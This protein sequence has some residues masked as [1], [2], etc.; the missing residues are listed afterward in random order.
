MG[1]RARFGVPPSFLSPSR[2]FPQSAQVS[3]PPQK[4]KRV[5]SSAEGVLPTFSLGSLA[6]RAGA[7]RVTVEVPRSPGPAPECQLISLSPD[8]GKGPREC[9]KIKELQPRIR[10]IRRSQHQLA[11]VVGRPKPVSLAF[12]LN[13]RQAPSP[14]AC[15]PGNYQG[16]VGKT[17][18]SASFSPAQLRS[19]AVTD[20]TSARLCA[21]SRNLFFRHPHDSTPRETGQAKQQ[22]QKLPGTRPHTWRKRE[23]GISLA[24]AGPP[25][26]RRTHLLLCCWIV[27]VM[28]LQPS[29]ITLPAAL[30]VK[31]LSESPCIST[32][33]SLRANPSP[34]AQIPGTGLITYS[35]IL[36]NQ[37]FFLIF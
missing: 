18:S 37:F 14:E 21:H 4:L 33:A 13:R 6:S 17:S 20:S 34:R 26:P 32:A 29:R 1:P 31:H 12:A 5:T 19:R 11:C 25:P 8:A 9:S 23:A 36:Q 2:P 35:G 22:Q 16:S 3:G 30:R 15:K 27:I 7:L 10:E 24:C 28:P